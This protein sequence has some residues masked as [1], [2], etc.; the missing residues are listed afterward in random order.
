MLSD[1]RFAFRQLAKS[2]GFTVVV[3]VSLALGI[4]ANT[5]VFSLLKGVLLQQ[6]PVQSPEQLVVFN[7]LGEENVRPYSLGGWMTREPGSGKATCTSF[8]IY[9]LEAFQKQT[10]TLSDVFG[11][12]P[13]SGLNVMVEGSAEVVDNAQVVS[14][15]YHRGLGVRAAVGRLIEPADDR[16]A[17]EPVAVISYD[18]WQR[19]FGGDAA[20]VGKVITVNAFRVTIVGVTAKGFQGAMQVGEVVDLTLPFSFSQR[21]TRGIDNVRVPKFWWV[22]IMG[23]L[24]PEFT[25]EQTRS[26]LDGT[27]RQSA[28]GN[29]RVSTLPGAPAID[30]TKVPLPQLRAEPGGQGLYE[31]RRNYERSLGLLTGI[32]ALV[33]LVACSNVANLLLARGAARRREIAL[34]LALGASRARIVRQLLAESVLLSLIG[35]AGGLLFAMWAT[36]TLI[37][38]HPFGTRPF[39]L[40]TSLDWRMLAF[41]MSAALATGVAFGLAPALRATRINL[42][43]EFQGGVRCLGAGSRSGL[44]RSLIVLQVAL[45]IV[46][47]VGA[48][49]F[50][51]TLQNLQHVDVGFKTDQ[52]LLFKIDASATGATYKESLATYE[53]IRERIAGL[54][55]VQMVSYASVPLLSQ[56]AWNSSISVPGRIAARNEDIRVNNVES[57]YLATMGIPL[58]R[59]RAFTKGDVVGTTKVAIVNQSFAK[60]FF[61]TEDVL[62]RRFGYDADNASEIEIVGLVND[63]LYND[64]KVL[65]RPTALFPYAQQDA[66]RGGASFVVR[67]AGSDAAVIS[68]ART[69]VHEVDPKLPLTNVR[70]Q[71]QQIDRLF[72]QERL[73]AYLCSFFGGLA[74]VLA[75]IG[76]YGLVSYAVIRRTG[77]I[78]LRMAL[79][80]LPADVLR[81][82]LRESI[83]LVFFG[84]CLGTAAALVATRTISNLLY[85]LS[86]TNPNTYFFAGLI[87]LGISFLASLLPARRAARVDPMTALRAE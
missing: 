51:R 64:V 52:L 71:Q 60:K 62:G 8:S 66:G 68:A 73:L 25:R 43:E 16:P 69:A 17:A 15:N 79:G 37:A 86:A 13:Q 74:L 39:Q 61:G 72:T 45:T 85:G 67:F 20:V 34:R 70:T 87:L 1:L 59:G 38:M 23:R 28:L 35:A 44:A 57:T 82:I 77:E 7:W 6:L 18:Y 81:M 49:L 41:T 9:T 29:V 84:V 30:P 14:G 32:V 5:T 55:A 76:L 48:G 83:G 75:A 33:L 80:A 65:P 54:P 56:D 58:R 2:P 12:S 50:V 27:F 63:A 3:I 78:G 26:D 21:T 10:T 22:R 47:L 46:L 24:K 36:P 42:T 53:R 31:A 4:G 40:E 11:F 19:R